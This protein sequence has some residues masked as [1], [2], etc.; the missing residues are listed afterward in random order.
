MFD[1]MKAIAVPGGLLVVA[2]SGDLIA[3]DVP[4]PA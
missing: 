1:P 3:L 4:A 2:S